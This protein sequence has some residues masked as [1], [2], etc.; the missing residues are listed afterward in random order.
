MAVRNITSIVR[1][2]NMISEQQRNKRI[3][4]ENN[5]WLRINTIRSSHDDAV[6]FVDTVD[7]LYR[8]HLGTRFEKWMKAQNVEY[9]RCGNKLFVSLSLHPTRFVESKVYYTP[10]DNHVSFT[11]QGYGMGESYSTS[12][13]L[14]HFI[15]TYLE[16]DHRYDE[17]LTTMATRLQ[18]FL[19]AFFDWVSQL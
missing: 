12:Q 7:A 3:M 2:G 5:F 8:N 11:W 14:S 13:D 15:H 19:S 18:P 4:R 16:N 9:T 10:S 1:Q 6:D 17:L